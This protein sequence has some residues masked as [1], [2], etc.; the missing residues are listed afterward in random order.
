MNLNA[1]LDFFISNITHFIGAFFVVVLFLFAVSIYLGLKDEKA[2]EAD[3][4]DLKGLEE[5][6]RKVIDS[7]PAAAAGGA[8]PAEVKKLKSELS[9]REK[10]LEEL[11]NSFEEAKKSFE[12]QAEAGSEAGDG[13]AILDGELQKKVEELEARLAEYE[14]IEDDIA[15]L[16]VY[17]E[18][19]NKL[20]ARL[21]DEVKMLFN[22]TLAETGPEKTRF[23]V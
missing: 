18:E 15:N 6:L 21:D 12:S 23:I 13:N 7:A 8:D 10:E 20:R 17:K 16:S 14:I 1:A 2:H 9:V 4:S 3:K 19:N 5:T 22:K 11:K